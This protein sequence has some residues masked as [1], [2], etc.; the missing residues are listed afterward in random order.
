MHIQPK[1][2]GNQF[3]RRDGPCS[4]NPVQTS[5][6]AVLRSLA[7]TPP[8]VGHVFVNLCFWDLSCPRGPGKPFQKVGGFAPHLLERFPGP[9]GQLIPQ[10]QRF[11]K[12]GPT[13]GGVCSKLPASGIH[14][15][16]CF[17]VAGSSPAPESINPSL[18]DSFAFLDR[19]TYHFQASIVEGRKPS[20][21]WSRRLFL[22]YP[23]LSQTPRPAISFQ[24]WSVRY[25]R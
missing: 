7:N 25:H 19:C 16:F 22:F 15:Y 9:P 18:T 24:H 20:Q 5:A 23:C 13:W 11:G 4:R 21:P 10:K 14:F 17:P 3:I 12:P 1:P 6:V 8:Q 2:A